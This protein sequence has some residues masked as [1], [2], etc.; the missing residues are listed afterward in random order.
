MVV[1]LQLPLIAL[2]CLALLCTA[3]CKPYESN[4]PDADDDFGDDDDAGERV[5]IYELVVRLFGNVTQNPETD[6]DILTNGVGR[7]E[8][9]DDTALQSL[10][11]LEIGRAS[12][13]E[14]VSESV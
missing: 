4:D 12:C 7:F 9:I 6:G 10:S 8:S 11:D 14:R 3:G 5:V 1:R 2:L 13:R